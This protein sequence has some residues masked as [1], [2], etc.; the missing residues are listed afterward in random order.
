MEQEVFER[1]IME[2][3][4]E[5]NEE[6]FITLRKQYL[7][8]VVISRE[9]TGRG[10]FTGYNIPNELVVEGMG[11]IIMDI[12]ARFDDSDLV[13]MFILFVR[14]GKIDCLEGVT[15]LGDWEYNYDRAILQYEFDDRRHHEIVGYPSTS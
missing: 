13:Y 15:V 8:S 2:K 6:P 14:E 10:F 12:S 4:L 9:F 3:M 7:N 1:L 5:P 11:G